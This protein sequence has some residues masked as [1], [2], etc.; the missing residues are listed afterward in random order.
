M[1]RRGRELKLQKQFLTNVIIIII[2][3]SSEDWWNLI[4]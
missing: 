2:I 1:K 4:V 3:N